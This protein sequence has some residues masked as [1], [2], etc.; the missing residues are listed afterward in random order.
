MKKI[1]LK[2]KFNKCVNLNKRRKKI[3]PGRIEK[4]IFV[5]K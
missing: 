5:G 3:N 4:E 2:I 1:F